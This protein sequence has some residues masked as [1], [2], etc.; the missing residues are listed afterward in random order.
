MRLVLI[1]LVALA[2]WWIGQ[3]RTPLALICGDSMEPN[4]HSGQLVRLTHVVP[5][6]I[7]RGSIV[8]INRFPLPP[9]VK[10]VVGLPG[11]IV[12]FHL[13][14]V[15]VDGKM[16]SE[17]YL[18]ECQTTFSW[19]CNELTP[20]ASAYVVLGDNRLI[21]EDSRQ[22]GPI[23]HGKILALIDAPASR[24]RFLDQPHYRIR[25][26]KF[27]SG[28]AGSAGTRVPRDHPL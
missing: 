11:E 17:D 20:T 4:L 8:L 1:L 5:P 7:G 19:D 22:Y 9:C 3:R 12:S 16:L 18:P 14:E 28:S 2:G 13:G 24:T 25:P 27:A 26:A 15:F 23:P 21:S 6:R 10:R